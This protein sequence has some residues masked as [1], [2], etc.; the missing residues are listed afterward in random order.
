MSV[1]R[2]IHAPWCNYASVFYL[3]SDGAFIVRGGVFGLGGVF[4][5]SPLNRLICHSTTSGS[6]DETPSI[7][8]T[9]TFAHT[10]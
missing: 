1:S 5:Q 10:T 8:R 6:N 9:Y 2:D 7:P 3:S 4:F